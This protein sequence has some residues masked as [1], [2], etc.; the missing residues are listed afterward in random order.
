MV[1]H[2]V[3]LVVCCGDCVV[4]VCMDIDDNHDENERMRYYFNAIMVKVS[5]QKV[6]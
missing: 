1:P 6:W 4:V 2:K 5:I 3:V